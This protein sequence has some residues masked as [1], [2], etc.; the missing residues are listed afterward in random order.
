[1]H[2]F[3]E[4]LRRDTCVTVSDLEAAWSVR[5]PK[6][7]LVI[8]VAIPR[9]VSEWFVTVTD[10]SGQELWHDW[11]DYYSTAGETRGQ[12]AA[13]MERDLRWFIDHAAA[14]AVRINRSCADSILE[15]Q[16]DDRWR[17][18]SLYVEA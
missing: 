3:I 11:M 16:I 13:D 2:R 4:A 7:E 8:E 1:M 6:P 14:S 15:W 5:I 17:Q 10:P 9:D 12:L 18:I